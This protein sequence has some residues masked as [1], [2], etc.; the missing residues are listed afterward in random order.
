LLPARLIERKR[1]GQELTAGEL[2]SFLRGYLDGS[3]QEPQMAA[4]LMAVYFRGLSAAELDVFVEVM[5]HSG[6]VLHSR[7]LAGPAVDKHSTGGV[8]DKTSLPLAPLCAELGLIVPM[9]S[10]RGLGH[11]GG[12]LDK[13]ESIPGFRTALQGSEM[14]TVLDSVGCVIS[15]QT[16]QMAAL[17]RRLYALRDVTATVSSIPLI[18]AS[19]MSKKLAEDLDGLVL[20]VKLGEGAFIPEED[21]A[22]ELA[23]TMVGI[24]NRRGVR[25]RALLTAMDRPLGRAIGNALEVSESI[26]CLRGEG[27]A[28]LSALVIGLAAE[29]LA[30]GEIESRVDEARARSER[31]L[32]S[33]V[34]LDRFRR[35]VEA[36][37]GDP[38]VVEDPTRLPQARERVPFRS[39]RRGFVSAIVPSVL[40]VAVIEMGGGRR[41]LGDSVDPSVG[42]E[43]HVPVGEAVA[44]GETLATVHAADARGVEIGLDALSRALR[45]VDT[46]EEMSAALPLF[47]YRVLSDEVVR[48]NE[49]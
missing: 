9:I 25:T 15:G 41:R 19:I 2:E 26:A 1:N 37:G 31:A 6:A 47:S 27:P 11:T 20:D 14:R 48:L 12:T 13:L 23:R 10:G 30:A 38:A 43:I 7:G 44:S 28:D 4:F 42:F 29:M 24:G 45:V 8:G 5:L 40:G 49:G 36:Q 3:V 39:T 17:D 16:E 46:E 35:M 34:G 22:L 18:S 21:R 33:G 32:A